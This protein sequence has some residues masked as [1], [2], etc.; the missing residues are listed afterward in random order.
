L[1]D[2]PDWTT[3]TEPATRAAPGPGDARAA[4]VPSLVRACRPKQWA[5][6]VLVFVAPA[7]AGVLTDAYSLR[8]TLQAFVA[9]CAVSSATYL[10]NDTL[11]IESDRR[12]PTKRNRPIA[13]GA[14]PIPV[15]VAAAVVL[16]L[17]GVALAVWTNPTLAGVVAGYAVLTTA[18][19]MFLKQVPVLDLVI[20]SAGFILRLL[21]GAYAAGVEV[22]EW[23]LLVSLFGSLFIAGAKRFA[24][25]KEL[26]EEAASLRPTL[27]AYSTD[28]L[29]FVRSVAAAAV[30]ISYCQ[31]AVE[32]GG[33]D[34]YATPWVQLSIIPFVI[35]ILRYALLVD[36]GQGSAPEEV[37]GSDRQMQLM[38]VLLVVCLALAV[39][40]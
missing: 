11:D 30:M 23:F 14:V 16:F 8:L 38:G 7:A 12:H 39:Y 27:G 32:S 18:Y 40:A 10:L 1:P 37:F 36:Q 22:S 15:A 26:G 19:S 2:T 5:K 6:N 31:W 21:G 17:G 34:R 33:T 29:G 9:F 13:S 35:A 4:L 3:V 20:L 28:Y 25:K 24:E